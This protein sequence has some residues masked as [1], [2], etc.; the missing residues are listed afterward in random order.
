MKSLRKQVSSVANF[1]GFQAQKFSRPLS[2]LEHSL[3][4]VASILNKAEKKC[5]KCIAGHP[6]LR[7]KYFVTNEN[8]DTIRISRNSDFC[9][10]LIS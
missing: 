1:F 4:R 8:L 7:F 6:A 2:T 10:P 5:W 3:S 9:L